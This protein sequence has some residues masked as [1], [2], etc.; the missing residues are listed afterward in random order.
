MDALEELPRVTC[1]VATREGIWADRRVTGGNGSIFTPHVKIIRGDGVVAG[2]CGDSSD[3]A[4]AMRAVR[5]GETDPNALAAL[6]S[7]LVVTERGLYELEGT[8]TRA[9]ANMPFMVNGSGYA[10]AQAFLYGA[11][12]WDRATIKRALRYVSRVRFDCG[13]G[14][15][16]L[17]LNGKAK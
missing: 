4:R 8:A 5:D 7:G 12:A 10:E 15:N 1:L 11:G 6:C 3:C 14:T 13:D 9:R 17:I 2:F 16:E